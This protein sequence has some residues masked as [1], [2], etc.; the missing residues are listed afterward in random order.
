MINRGSEWGKWDLHVHTPYSTLNNE[1][2]NPET[3]FEIYVRKML[4][5]AIEKKI[6]VVGLTDYY[7]I[8]GY[9][10][11]KEEYLKN[12]NKLKK[13]SNI[14]ASTISEE[15]KK[16]LEFSDE[17]IG[18]IKEILFLPNIE[19]REKTVI[20]GHK[21]NFHVI[22]SDKVK[23]DEIKTYFLN[24]IEYEHKRKT[25]HLEEKSLKDLGVIMKCDNPKL[26]KGDLAVG[27][28]QVR[29]SISEVI[30]KL[31]NEKRFLN[32]YL[33][34]IDPDEDLSKIDWISQ[35][36]SA[37]KDF[38][39]CSDA[40]FTSEKNTVKFG[41]AQLPNQ[42]IKKFK[43]TFGGLK[44]T[45][46]GSDAHNFE[47]MFEPDLKRYTWIKA[48]PTFE[49]LKQVIIEPEKRIRI[50]ENSPNEKIARETIKSIKFINK[51]EKKYKYICN[52]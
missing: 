16:D 50:Q 21:V 28:E 25:Y 20:G 9:Q 4:K 6:K 36:S 3:Q 37:R 52:K 45:F 7:L 33:I 31:K 2:G 41:L 17:E 42:S 26:K 34:L 11:F 39:Y 32:K 30:E 47:K 14:Y 8:E 10:R 46:H 49:G 44:P 51:T 13:I 24:K 19:F 40:F 29:I 1:F 38:I 12:T 22:F 5:K 18:Q 27:M 35:D 48:R 15:M 23:P 43:E